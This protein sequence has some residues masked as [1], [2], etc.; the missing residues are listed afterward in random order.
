MNP[1]DVSVPI[2]TTARPITHATQTQKLEIIDN[3]TKKIFSILIGGTF[4]ILLL[5]VIVQVVIQAIW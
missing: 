2:H 4:V 3:K 5:I 1:N